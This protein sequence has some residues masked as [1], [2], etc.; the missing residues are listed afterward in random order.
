M[1]PRALN[2]LLIIADAQDE[3]DIRQKL[4]GAA[5]TLFAVHA[6]ASLAQATKL[7]ADKPIDIFL[8]DLAVPD[9]GGIQGLQRL[10]AAAHYAPV[11]IIT[12]IY[13]ESQAL[14][15]VRA[16]ADDYVVKSRMN[17]A[18]FERVLGKCANQLIHIEGSVHGASSKEFR[19][20]V[21]VTPDPNWEPQ[22]EIPIEDGMFAGTVLFNSTESEGRVE[23]DCSRTPKIVQVTLLK[24]GHEVDRV[25]LDIAR[26]FVK[27][28]AGE[29]K[30][31]SPVIL[32][33]QSVSWER[34]FH[35]TP[36]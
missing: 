34:E 4:A 3:A 22:V 8:I 24:D 27:D 26:D 5:N 18:A 28:K 1:D 13:D 6:A 2:V 20:S 23:D 29:Y 35:A 9:S 7:I 32:H 15:V 16:G 33:S 12:S 14:E 21:D 31:R 36:Q 30:L 17:A 25:R 19:I 11:I 10:I